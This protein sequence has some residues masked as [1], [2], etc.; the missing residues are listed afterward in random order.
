MRRR[1]APTAAAV[2]AT[3]ACG[4]VLDAADLQLAATFTFRE[5]PRSQ[6]VEHEFICARWA[7]AEGAA[8]PHASE[9][10]DPAWHDAESIPFDKCV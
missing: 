5:A 3:A 8:A 6:Y 7:L 9:A 2:R 10:L 4:V 1:E